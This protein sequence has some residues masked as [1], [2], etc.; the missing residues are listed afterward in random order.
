[1]SA[2][3]LA[4]LVRQEIIA[5][6]KAARE[7]AAAVEAA[8]RDFTTEERATVEH[9]TTQAKALQPKLDQHLKAAAEADA[10]QQQL[11]DLTGGIGLLPNSGLATP[12]GGS[13]RGK[14]WGRAVVAACSDGIRFKGITPSGSVVVAVPAPA[15][16]PAGR[17]VPS[18]RNLLPSEDGQ[19]RFSY[20]R[21]IT[22]T[23][24]ATVVAP[25]AKKPTSIYETVLIDDRARV[26]AHLTEPIPR[27]D[28]MDAPLLEQWVSS[29]LLYGLEVALEAEILTGN[30][31][32]EHLTG[33]NNI[34]GVQVQTFATNV[35]TTT[36]KA[37][38]RLENYGY[39]GTGWI[40][41]PSSWEAVEL[42]ATS[43]GSLLV[44]EAG[45]QAP[46][47]SSTRRLWGAPVVTSVAC[48]ANTAFYADFSTMALML[49]EQARIDWSEALY[50]PDRFGTGDGGTLFEAN[51]IV[52]RCE[53]RAGLKVT[54]PDAIVK[55]ALA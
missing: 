8:G 29:E 44:T 20:F 7:V 28:L 12:D 36:R 13:S 14:T 1:M 19:G 37:V 47:E 41:S 42:A 17:P 52:G 48:P 40:M 32:G 24:N 55:V 50:S 22:R 34:S 46:I 5:H 54:R 49:T 45:Q 3:G 6:L 53:M 39:H 4:D 23:N 11:A 30:G 33:L 2:K 21:Q 43:T 51:Q 10:L 26:V 25:G 27:Q 35:I 31:T 38:T 9:H 16:A 15:V 18:L